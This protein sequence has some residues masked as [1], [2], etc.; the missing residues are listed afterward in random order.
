MKDVEVDR[1][2]KEQR[3]RRVPGHVLRRRHMMERRNKSNI[4]ERQPQ[5]EHAEACWN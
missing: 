1:V 5:G 4:G 3:K 2:S